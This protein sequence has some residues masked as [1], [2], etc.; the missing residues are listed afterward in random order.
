MRFNLHQYNR[1]NFY[2]IGKNH[3]FTRRET[4]FDAAFDILILIFKLKKLLGENEPRKKEKEK[5]RNH[6]DLKS[7]ISNISHQPL[8]IYDLNV[9]T[10]NKFRLNVTTFNFIT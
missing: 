8:N 7:L 5:E 9:T 1:F 6:S 2:K 3:L 10:L 4:S